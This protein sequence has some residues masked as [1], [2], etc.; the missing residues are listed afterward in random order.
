[1]PH[2]VPGKKRT[3]FDYGSERDQALKAKRS[4]P[5]A[6]AFNDNFGSRNPDGSMY[7]VPANKSKPVRPDY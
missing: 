4:K 3:V 2:N 5:T 6:R 7:Q 1:M